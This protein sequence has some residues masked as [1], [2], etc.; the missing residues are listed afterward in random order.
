MKKKNIL[1]SVLFG[2]VLAFGLLVAACDNGVLP[3]YH[4]DSNHKDWEY[5]PGYVEGSEPDMGSGLPGYLLGG[6]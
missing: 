2:L 4:T 6:S 1:I 5:E 3:T